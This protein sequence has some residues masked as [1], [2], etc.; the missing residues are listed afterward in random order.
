M[1]GHTTSAAII[2]CV[3]SLMMFGF[4][5]S[6]WSEPDAKRTHPILLVIT[7]LVFVVSVLKLLD[8]GSDQREASRAPS[9]AFGD[10]VGRHTS[11]GPPR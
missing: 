2:A 10:T 8:G 7:A 9:S 4:L 5:A 3:F 11:D 1:T 6:T